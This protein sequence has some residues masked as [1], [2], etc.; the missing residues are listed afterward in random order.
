M[1]LRDQ[2]KSIRYIGPLRKIPPRGFEASLSQK[3]SAWSDGM[4]AWETLLTNSH[5]LV[6][7]CSE[8]MISE[9]KLNA[10]YSI[11]RFQT[12]EMDLSAPIAQP[13]G[14][15]KMRL[16]LVDQAGLE[17]QP[18][19]LGVGISQVLP[20]VV[21]AQD[22]NASIVCIEQP[23]LHVHPGVQLGLGDLFIDGAHKNGLSFLIETHSE[24]LIVRL[25][26][27]IR[28]AKRDSALEI[29]YAL[30]PDDVNIIYLD[31]NKDGVVQ[32]NKIRLGNDGKFLDRWPNGFF[33][34]RMR[35]TLPKEVRDRLNAPTE[36]KNDL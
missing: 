19:D 29:H 21:A 31:K 18:Q 33:P 5:K 23:E 6:N 2:L 17:H 34:E 4:A 22:A 9:G 35:E 20:V 7:D 12:Q 14:N 36:Q 25:Q 32:V 16:R 8:W 27:R 11:R 10:G 26:R 30:S 3:D 15:P 1:L 28:E 24:N 13:I